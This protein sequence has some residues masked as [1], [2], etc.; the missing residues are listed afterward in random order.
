MQTPVSEK[1]FEILKVI[2]RGTFGKVFQARKSDTGRMM[3]ENAVLKR[4]DHPFIVNLKYAFQN[5]AHLFMVIDFLSGG[6]LFYHLNQHNHFTEQRAK[7][8]CAEVVSAIGY[9]H[10]NDI[11]YRDLK[12]ENLVLDLQGH[13]CLVDFGL[14]RMDLTGDSKTN[15]FCGSAEYMAPE[16]LRGMPYGKAIDWWA[17]GILV[18]EML[19]GL[20]PF[21][22]EDEDTM[23]NK[24]QSAP[25]DLPN[26][27]TADAKD[28]LSRILIRD[29]DAR[30][31]SGVN[32]TMDV[33]SH[34]W[35]SDIDWIALENREVQP[36]FIPHL[37]SEYD[38]AYVD[39]SILEEKA[40][41][42]TTGPCRQDP[43][44]FEGFSYDVDV[45]EYKRHLNNDNV[46]KKITKQLCVGDNNNVAM[47]V[48][49]GGFSPMKMVGGFDG[50]S[51]AV[52]SNQQQLTKDSDLIFALE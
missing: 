3:A 37:Q 6:E 4:I 7:F 42:C 21:W 46:N 39:D 49:S 17:L 41:I 47:A 34:S 28:F 29:P 16:V 30:L 26:Y 36:E 52:A 38:L 24:I 23:Q 45:D 1:D 22:D 51:S 32:G 2:G 5:E 50:N 9:L 27:L 48:L 12:P 14:C 18:Y 40:T 10:E 31:G 44:P 43:D 15:T 13:V 20:P 35:L 8:Y 25:L 19:T 33:K 11:L